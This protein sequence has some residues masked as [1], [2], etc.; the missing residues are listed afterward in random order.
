[1]YFEAAGSFSIYQYRSNQD[2]GDAKRP[3]LSTL[4]PGDQEIHTIQQTVSDKIACTNCGHTTTADQ[5]S[6]PCMVCQETV[7]TQAVL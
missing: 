1:M 5:Q 6:Q 4:P 2:E 7:W 3:G